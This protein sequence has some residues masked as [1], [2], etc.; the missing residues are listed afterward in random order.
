MRWERGERCERE[1]EAMWSG[2]RGEVGASR[3]GGE[4]GGRG[5]REGEGG[6]PSRRAAAWLSHMERRH[7]RQRCIKGGTAGAAKRPTI[8]AKET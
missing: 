4:G 1:V 8:G 7:G 3:E 6:R 5:R 2:K